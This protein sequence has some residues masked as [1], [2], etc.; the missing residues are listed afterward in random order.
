MEQKT[1]WRS[2]EYG[3]RPLGTELLEMAALDPGRRLSALRRA[4]ET[5]NAAL[6]A[7]GTALIRPYPDGASPWY[8]D[9]AGERE[10]EMERWLRPRLDT[11]PESMAATLAEPSPCAP[12]ARPTVLALHPQGLATGGLWLVWPHAGARSLGQEGSRLA[13]GE[14]EDFRRA[15]ESLVEVEHKERLYFRHG[16]T[17]LDEELARALRGE[18]GEALPALL[19]LARTIGGADLAYWGSVHDGVVDVEWHLGAMDR[20]FGSS[21]PWATVSAAGPLSAAR[22]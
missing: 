19:A 3:L 14:M 11:S 6:S 10:K 22:R 1:G 16:A 5:I 20:G 2:M 4:L 21:C 8:A 9:Y 15:L 7:A 13:R 18:D 17:P 12:G